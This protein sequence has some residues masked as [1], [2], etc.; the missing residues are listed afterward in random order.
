MSGEH[1]GAAGS[2]WV[3]SP[4]ALCAGAAVL[5]RASGGSQ[6][7]RVLVAAAVPSKHDSDSDTARTTTNTHAG[8]LHQ[9]FALHRRIFASSLRTASLHM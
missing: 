5:K 6:G 1:V 3:G 7:P 2:S 9:L 8:T 4:V